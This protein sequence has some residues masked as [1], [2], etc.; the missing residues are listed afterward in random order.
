MTSLWSYD[1]D[2]AEQTLATL[3]EAGK[4]CAGGFAMTIDGEKQHVTKVSEEKL[5]AGEDAVA[6][7]VGTKQDAAADTSTLAG[8][9]SFN[10]A[11]ATRGEAFELPTAVIDAQAAK[12]G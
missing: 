12:L 5:S 10:I 3:R 1:A 7:T 6:W 8:F 4:K 9:S 11:A 2:G